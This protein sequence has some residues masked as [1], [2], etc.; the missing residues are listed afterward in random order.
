MEVLLSD[1]EVQSFL[2]FY[3]RTQLASVL[4]YLVKYS[5]TRLKPNHP[6]LGELEA[7]SNTEPQE[8]NDILKKDLLKIRSTLHKLDK[9]MA[10]TLK[11]HNILQHETENK[12][13]HRSRALSEMGV[14]L[15]HRNYNGSMDQTGPVKRC[16]ENAVSRA[17]DARRVSYN[18]KLINPQD[19]TVNRRVNFDMGAQS[20]T[21]PITYEHRRTEAFEVSDKGLVY[22]NPVVDNPYKGAADIATE[23]LNNS[24]I[25][26]FAEGG[27]RFNAS[28]TI[29]QM[30]SN[31]HKVSLQPDMHIKKELY[32]D[33][34]SSKRS[35]NNYERQFSETTEKINTRDIEDWKEIK[36]QY[37]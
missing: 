11:D 8:I 5:I 16:L 6:T 33:I 29:T 23:F 13:F 32:R 2:S 18:E 1:P 17:K 20:N 36:H 4:L 21:H 12:E 31:Y 3:P 9:K 30:P 35:K 10:H 26:K 28:K 22:D 34:P 37:I 24:V 15:N 7:W 27:R 19:V 14:Q 25:T